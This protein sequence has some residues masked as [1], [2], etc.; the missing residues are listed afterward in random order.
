MVDLRTS[1][2]PPARAQTCAACRRLNVAASSTLCRG[3]GLRAA[4]IGA[5]TAALQADRSSSLDKAEPLLPP[6]AGPA[7]TVNRLQSAAKSVRVADWQRAEQ[8]NVI[9]DAFCT[10]GEAVERSMPF[11][12]SIRSRFDGF[13]FPEQRWNTFLLRTPRFLQKKLSHQ[14]SYFSRCNTLG[15]GDLP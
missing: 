12:R 1:W 10:F 7:A 3:V 14:V 15:W 5:R 4:T 8:L 2:K 9:S 6:S 13:N 11:N